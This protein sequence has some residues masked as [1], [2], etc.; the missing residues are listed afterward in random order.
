MEEINDWNDDPVDMTGRTILPGMVLN[1]TTEELEESA[2]KYLY[3]VTR[4]RGLAFIDGHNN[5]TIASTTEMKIIGWF[6]DFPKI[7][8]D[9]TLEIDFAIN[10]ATANFIKEAIGK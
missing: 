3:C 1:L 2:F 7:V 8:D 4:G 5:H 6:W 9:E 10:R